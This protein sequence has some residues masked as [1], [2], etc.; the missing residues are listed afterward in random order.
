MKA[1]YAFSGDPITKGHI[2]IIE[3]AAATYDEVTVAIG[4]NPNKV[5][6]YLFSAKERIT[7]AKRAVAHLAN[8]DCVIFEGLLAQFAYR[9]GYNVIIRGVRNSADLE[10][11]LTLYHVNHLQFSSIDTVILPTKPT[12][13]H[14]SS[15]VVRALVSEGGDVSEYVPIH[16][17]QKLE[18]KISGQLRIGVAGGIGS[19]KSFVASGLVNRVVNARHIDLDEI[20][21]Y[22]LSN[23]PEPK[24]QETRKRIVMQ[25]GS[26]LLEKDGSVNRSALGAIVFEDPRK[27]SLLNDI[28]LKPILAHLYELCRDNHMQEQPESLRIIFL[29]SGLFVENHLTHLVNHCMILVTCPDDLKIRRMT[30]NRGMDEDE[31]KQKIRRE[32]SDKRRRTYLKK[33]L[34]ENDR[35]FLIEF[36]NKE[37]ELPDSFLKEVQERLDE[38]REV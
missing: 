22:I 8:V 13:S 12:L 38:L 23:S 3:R 10:A 34:A 20:G 16:V 15:S 29:E 18:Q 7:M 33:K 31:A 14:V 36:D 25:F 28:M 30:K 26:T 37:D 27:L 19:G 9:N 5:G 21:H 4:A 2:D 1:I 6:G 32:I 17:K 11:E 35:S 24:Y